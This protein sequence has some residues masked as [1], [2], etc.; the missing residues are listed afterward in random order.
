VSLRTIRCPIRIDG[1]VLKSPVGAPRV[2][3]HDDEISEELAVES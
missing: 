1:E 3:A 2:G